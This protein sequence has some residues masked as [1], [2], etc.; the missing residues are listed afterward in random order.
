MQM[1]VGMYKYNNFWMYE[2]LAVL[3][4]STL[5]KKT[6]RRSHHVFVWSFLG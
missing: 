6:C 3:I 4:L 2:E 5:N 1:F